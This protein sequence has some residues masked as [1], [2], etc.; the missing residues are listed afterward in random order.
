MLEKYNINCTSPPLLFS[1]LNPF[2]FDSR[3]HTHSHTEELGSKDAQRTLE[4]SIL[5]APEEG[6][7]LKPC[8][9]DQAEGSSSLPQG[10]KTSTRQ[11][12]P[13]AAL[14]LCLISLKEEAFVLLCWPHPAEGK[15]ICVCN[16]MTTN[17]FTLFSSIRPPSCLS[18]YSPVCVA[19]RGLNLEED[20]RYSSGLIALVP[21]KTKWFLE[22]MRRLCPPNSLPY[23]KDPPKR[24]RPVFDLPVEERMR[25]DH[26]PEGIIRALYLALSGHC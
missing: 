8:G 12:C 6:V 2:V 17:G 18:Y 24:Q 4:P 14:K 20:R 9:Q 3:R 11:K 7:T 15:R 21:G 10:F 1:V 23:L 22:R 26:F 16:R 19:M 13:W 5:P 25:T